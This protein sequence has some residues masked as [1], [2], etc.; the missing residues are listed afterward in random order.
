[1]M[2]FFSY[3]FKLISVWVVIFLAIGI[4]FE[5]YFQ[6][7][8]YFGTDHR[9]SDLIEHI[10][11]PEFGIWRKPNQTSNLPSVFNKKNKK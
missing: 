2:K 10:V 1:M 5:M 11:V 8:Q 3:A 6:I 7:K 4:L 9:R